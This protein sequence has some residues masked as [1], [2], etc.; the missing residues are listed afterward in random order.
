MSGGP[1]HGVTPA[2]PKILQCIDCLVV[3]F[4]MRCCGSCFSPKQ[5]PLASERDVA[6]ETKLPR[7]AFSHEDASG[8]NDHVHTQSRVSP[9]DGLMKKEDASSKRIDE[10]LR[11]IDAQTMPSTAIASLKST[12]HSTEQTSLE[13]VVSSVS[14][15]S[16]HISVKKRELHEEL[17]EMK[18][19]DYCTR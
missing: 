17:E 6:E 9:D 13:P 5:T 3:V 18:R 11:V 10:P 19:C 4:L 7:Y 15:C 8:V 12:P 1:N 16:H 14:P 2:L